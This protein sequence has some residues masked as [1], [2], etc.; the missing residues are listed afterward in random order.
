MPKT[1][2]RKSNQETK[3]NHDKENDKQL[4]TAEACF[5]ALRPELDADGAEEVDNPRMELQAAAVQ[6]LAV[7]HTLAEPAVH[8]TIAAIAKTGAI[9]IALV[10]GLEK[11]AW[12][13]WFARHK[14]QQSSITYTEATLPPAIVAEAS[15]L[16]ARMLKT[17]SY[18]LEDD[19]EAM[20]AIA[21][22]RAGAGHL[23]LADDLAASAA[24]YRKHQ[25]A[26]RH[27]PKNYRAT[28]VADAERLSER[29]LRLLGAS[30]VQEHAIWQRYAARAAK[31]L[32][33]HY[34]EAIR[35]G[36]FLFHRDDP[37]GRFPRLH[38][39]TRA[40]AQRNGNKAA[41]PEE[42]KKAPEDAG[43][44]AEKKPEEPKKDPADRGK[45]AEKQPD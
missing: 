28:D 16:R 32:F 37:E 35:V 7:A 5:E 43:K 1:N 27:D 21:N 40:P 30:P 42:P 15:E 9:D 45:P 38:T 18:H 29:I 6:A 36:R 2:Q 44:A 39:A 20:A 22:I 13:T 23:D 10:D 31:L 4:L 8:K 19:A 17:L 33:S 41:E 3:T 14:A 25:D 34:E 24:L 26:I 11:V 12:A